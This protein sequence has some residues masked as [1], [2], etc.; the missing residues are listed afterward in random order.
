MQ[1]QSVTEVAETRHSVVARRLLWNNLGY[2]VQNIRP[3]GSRLVTGALKPQQT[4]D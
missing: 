2:V 1:E 4:S 3:A